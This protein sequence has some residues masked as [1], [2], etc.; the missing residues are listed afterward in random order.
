MT[1]LDKDTAYIGSDLYLPISKV[2]VQGIK[3]SLLLKAGKKSYKLYFE[4]DTHIVCPRYHIMPDQYDDIDC[5]FVKLDKPT[6]PTVNCFDSNILFRE[7]QKPAWDQLK[8]NDD[9]ILNL[10][11]GKGKTI[12]ALHKVAQLK[13]PTLIVV[14]TSML[15]DQWKLFIKKFL[16]CTDVGEIGDGAFDW[17]HPI[18]IALIHS[19]YNKKSFPKGFT[20]HF[21]F[22]IVD[23]GHHLGG[24]E[25]G[26]IGPLCKGARLL[27]SATYKRA[28]GREDIYRQY[29]GPIICT[30]KGFDLKPDIVFIELKNK[31]PE[32][33]SDLHNEKQI[34]ALGEDSN[35]N[36]DRAEIIKKYCK[37]RKSILVST[38]INQLKALHSVFPDSVCITRESEKETRMDLVR[39]SS[40]SFIIDNFGIEALDCEELDTLFILL[41]ISVNKSVQRDGTVSL[42]GNDLNQIMGRILRK[43]STKKPPLVVIFDD[44]YVESAHSQIV[45]IKL[46]FNNNNYP[47]TVIKDSK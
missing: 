14:N 42:L 25:F 20:E 43:C 10:A 38:R 9:G 29:F 37:D 27:L 41:P 35:S 36:K 11:P 23:E 28:D 34:S 31:L 30:D 3:N 45:N 12:L 2:N 46:W 5:S 32:E 39:S 17:E 18:T 21:G 8:V 33:I 26:K 47:F 40:L 24:M 6:F 7:E 15:V 19:L 13:V 4:T 44:I 16:N 22:M 1:N